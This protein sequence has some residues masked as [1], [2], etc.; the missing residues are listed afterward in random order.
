MGLVAR[1][2]ASSVAGELHLGTCTGRNKGLDIGTV[3]LAKAGD[4]F[5]DSTEARNKG[6]KTQNVLV[7]MKRD[8]QP[9]G[10][11]KRDIPTH[12]T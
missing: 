4:N 12:R 10:R 1:D 7:N 6:H 11:R 8:A 2:D 3:E 9:P 5:V